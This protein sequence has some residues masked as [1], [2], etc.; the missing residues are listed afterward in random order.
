MGLGGTALVKSELRARWLGLVPYP[1]A[2][3]LQEAL[4]REHEAD[5]LLLLEHP[6]T[7]TM[8]R[9]ARPQNLLWD[10]AMRRRR[11]VAVCEADRGGDITYHG[12][13][14]LVAYPI[15]S[16]RDADVV[17]YLR[18]LEDLI[19]RV[20]AD[21]GVQARRFPPFTGVWVGERKLA[22]IGVKVRAAT[23][24]HGVALNVAPD[25]EYW[26]GIVPCG[27]SGYGVTSLRDE[28]GDRAPTVREVARRF[29]AHFA[30]VFGYDTV[31]VAEEEPYSKLDSQAGLSIRRRAPARPSWMKVRARLGSEYMELKSMMRGLELHTVCEEAGCPNI[32]E[33]WG[34]R[35]ATLMILGS[36]CTRACGFCR[37]A[38]GRP[39]GLDLDEPN[40][41]AEAVERM[42]LAHAV[43][44]SVARDDL[45]DGGASVFA[46]TIRA[47]RRRLPGCAV[48]V[49]V[50]D[51]KGSKEALDA[52][53]AERPD[54]LN[55][56]IET[57]ARL[58]KP[59]RKSM[60]SYARTLTLL[61][62]AHR[63][64]LVTKSGIIVGM[65]ETSA[66]VV[67]TLRDLR[68]VGV[69]IV[70]IGHYLQ[71]T[72]RHLDV[73]R[74]VTPEEFD[75]YAEAARSLGFSHV[76]SGPLVRSSYHARRATEG[77][78]PRATEAPAMAALA[79]P[80]AATSALV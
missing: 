79:D 8:G 14:Q 36:Q 54:V 51:F 16:L 78:T 27:I 21:F 75:A 18:A 28:L 64:G 69:N 65:G 56:N 23:T 19:T 31:E 9:G 10:E 33:C 32:Y 15:I 62:R 55:H 17:A 45:A 49:L 22:A 57:V 30:D 24:K 40:R 5:Y 11:R 58:Q 53:I 61:S 6:H 50:P 52:V 3:D 60:A 74:W 4:F 20:V 1:E 77:A 80:M 39:E 13:G 76:E 26:S 43:I 67:T 47:I 72:A 7:Y 46:A 68:A 12:P 37:V 38:T 44:T 25:M 35:T 2:A 29:C 70:T 41:V 34:D 48:E 59:V 73:K 71:P 42:G 63:A 66:E